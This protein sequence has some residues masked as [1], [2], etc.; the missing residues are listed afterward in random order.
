MQQTLA[1]LIQRLDLEALEL[2]LFRGISADIGGRAVFGGQ[3]IGQ[4]LAA[5]ERTV[6]GRAPHSLHAYFLLP[7]DVTAPI[8]Y[9]VDRLRDGRSFSARRVLAV[10]H[11]QPILSAI[12]SFQDPEAGLEHSAP[13]PQVPGPEGLTSRA[14]LRERSLATATGVPPRVVEAL[15]KPS[16][17][18]FRPVHPV[19]PVRPKA[20]APAQSMWF[21]AVDRLPDDPA[22][23]RRLLA[24]VSD[25]QL[26]G[27]PLR[28]HARSWS[29]PAMYVASLD[30]AVWFHRPA[31]IDEWLLYTMDSPT[32][33]NARGFA[34]GAIFDRAGRLVASVAQE[35]L[36]REMTP[37]AHEP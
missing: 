10:Q 30:H 32:A 19:D 26:L 16:A 17:F 36:M 22:L 25:S 33:Q 18:D 5:A 24:Y 8:V 29:D 28:P 1:S 14:E 35:G 21:R 6:D 9:S 20:S 37:R 13:I 2:N 11:G 7:G 27:T 12:A 4:A 34:R 23:H 15:R 3:V 31:R